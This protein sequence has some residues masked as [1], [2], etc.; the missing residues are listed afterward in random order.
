MTE[1]AKKF[2]SV[3]YEM[4]QIFME[5]N[6]SIHGLI[7]AT[8]SQTNI[9]LLGPAGIAKSALINQWNR[10]IRNS[11]Y[12]SW[13]L[14]KFS[15]PEEIFGPPSLVGL[16]KEQ[17]Y[18]VTKRRLPEANTVFLDEV[19]KANSSILNAMLTV[20]NERVFYN[21]GIP[22]SLNVVT[23]AGASNEIP[24]A[25]DGLDAF[26]DR[27]LLKFT[28]RPIQES[29][30]FKKMLRSQ[31]MKEE[32]TFTIT[33]EDIRAAQQEIKSIIIPD[34]VLNH[35]TRL[36]ETLRKDGV[37][38]TDRT[39]KISMDVIQAEAWLN[40]RT[41]VA[42]DD[43]EVY[44]HICWNKP[45]QEKKVH[46]TILEVI[47][48]ERNKINTFYNDCQD[49]AKNVYKHHDP[50]K[51]Q[52][53]LIEANKKI[54]EARVEIGRLKKDMLSKKQD[55]SAIEKMENELEGLTISMASDV[56]GVNIATLKKD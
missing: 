12:F 15:T 54:K 10:R 7:L 44:R 37:A 18:R 47:S 51:R 38:V 3:E 20:L 21:D 25:D 42:S 35:I 53:A 23:I 43:L 9:L 45:D 8:L 34:V 39:F 49:V 24:E 40:G 11:A 50:V 28:L 56:L 31:A 16:E 27:F 55:I 6:E 14:T 2:R 19:F 5:R 22:V 48:P 13:L 36:R 46:S 33:L 52:Q 29:S 1:L 32:P 26:F 17:Y 30:N 41:E 4:G